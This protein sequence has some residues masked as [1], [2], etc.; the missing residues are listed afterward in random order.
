MKSFRDLFISSL[1]WALIITGAVLVTKCGVV[2]TVQTHAIESM[3]NDA[4]FYRARYMDNCTSPTGMLT[5]ATIGLD[6]ADWYIEQT[7]LDKAQAEA[8]AAMRVGGG[9]KLQMAALKKQLNIVKGKF[10]KWATS[11]R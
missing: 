9:E 2:W 5:T 10:S 3:V 4:T 11:V 7:R 1:V 8:V 6:C